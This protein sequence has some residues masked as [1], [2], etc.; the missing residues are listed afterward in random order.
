MA[1][2]FEMSLGIFQVCTGLPTCLSCTVLSKWLDLKSV[3]LLDSAL[4]ERKKRDVVSTLL[5]SIEC[6]GKFGAWNSDR[7]VW[8]NKRSIRTSELLMS[9]KHSREVLE[10]YLQR[11]GHHVRSVREGLQCTLFT[12]CSSALPWTY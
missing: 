9:D 2:N 1:H 3:C 10:E 5:Q 4:C 7:L 6:V 11:F 12:F 8:L